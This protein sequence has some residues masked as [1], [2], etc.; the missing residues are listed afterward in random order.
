MLKM[1]ANYGHLK[2]GTIINPIQSGFDFV[3]VKHRGSTL[4]VPKVLTVQHYFNESN[5]NDEVEDD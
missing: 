5:Y 4:H 3:V 1:I 2:A